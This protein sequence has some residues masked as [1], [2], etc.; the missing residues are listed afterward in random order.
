MAE[1]FGTKGDDDHMHAVPPEDHTPFSWTGWP[2]ESPFGWIFACDWSGPGFARQHRFWI[3]ERN[4]N[5]C[6]PWLK[7]INLSGTHHSWQPDY[8]RRSSSDGRGHGHTSFRSD[9][10]HQSAAAGWATVRQGDVGERVLKLQRSANWHG[11][12]LLVDGVDGP[13]TTHWIKT[14]QE[15][16]GLLVDGI[17]GPK[18]R[19]ELYVL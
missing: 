16:R 17:A 10:T 7:Y 18:T 13:K 15:S 19:I 12:N 2:I 8:E 14:F 1:H 9:F 3:W 6:A 5:H 11:A 4:T